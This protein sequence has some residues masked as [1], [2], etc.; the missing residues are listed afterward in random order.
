MKR[1]IL[2]LRNVACDSVDMAY[3][4]VGKCHDSM[5][6]GCKDAM[7][8]DPRWRSYTKSQRSLSLVQVS[9]KMMQMVLLLDCDDGGKIIHGNVGRVS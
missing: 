7:L 3:H 6:T 4:P 2:T 8:T 9:Q 5:Y 1:Y